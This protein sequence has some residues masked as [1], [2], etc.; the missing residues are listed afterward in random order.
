MT[1]FVPTETASVARPPRQSLA[2]RISALSGPARMFAAF[3][4]ALVVF[5]VIIRIKGA[6]PITAYHDMITSSFASWHAVGDIL[7]RATPIILAAIAVSVPARAGLINV[8]GEGQMLIGGIA[9]MGA[10]LALGDR[11]PGPAV[12]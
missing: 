12:I 1:T 9:A 8:G 3:V 11:I 6:N 5:G 4:G 10:S 2:A 7:V